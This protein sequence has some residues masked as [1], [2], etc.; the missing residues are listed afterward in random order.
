MEASFCIL[1][2]TVA[3]LE[4][5]QYDVF[6]IYLDPY[7]LTYDFVHKLVMFFYILA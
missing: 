4:S 5:L 6:A 1:T 3:Y 2:M 7:K